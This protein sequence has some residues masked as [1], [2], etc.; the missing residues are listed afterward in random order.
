MNNPAA[1]TARQLADGHTLL[2]TVRGLQSC[3]AAAP[4]FTFSETGRRNLCR[5]FYLTSEGLDAALAAYE[6][7][8]SL[9]P[10]T[11]PQ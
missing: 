4:V 9:A 3:L 7:T 5:R 2:Q 10:D 8:A 11:V 6:A 1:I